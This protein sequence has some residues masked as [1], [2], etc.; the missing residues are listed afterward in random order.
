MSTPIILDSNSLIVRCIMATA[1]QDLAAGIVPTGGVYGTLANLVSILTLPGLNPGAIYACFD[2]GVPKFRKELLPDYKE[3]RATRRELFTP[4]EK[5]TV[6]SQVAMAKKILGLL[7][8]VCLEYKQ[9]EADDTVAAVT[10]L[11]V[12]QGHEPLV[13]T[14]DKDVWQTIGLGA[15]VWDLGQT[16]IIDADNFE[17]YAHVPLSRY[18]LFKALVGDPS[19]SIRGAPSVGSG[20]AILLTRDYDLK[21]SPRKQLTML[22]EALAE[23]DKRP[24][25]EQNVI[26]ARDHLDTVLQAID[27]TKSFGKTRKL[28]EAMQRTP[29]CKL[30]PF[31]KYAR[32]LH[33]GGVLRDPHR[34]FKP[35]KEARDRR[36]TD[37]G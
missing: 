19:D 25:Y 11:C 28:W 24:K 30:L 20:R 26:E 34:F 4:E 31:L 37:A 9:R 18:L 14:G 7:G 8:V 21:G 15:R 23:K 33:L 16:A 12:K 10:R 5:E 35:F 32:K 3:A 1:K 13:V 36:L 2:N 17:T 6:F 22:C 29:D 27:L